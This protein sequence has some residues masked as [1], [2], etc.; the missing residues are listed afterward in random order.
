MGDSSPVR[1]RNSALSALDLPRAA[2]SLECW[3]AQW[4]G[5]ENHQSIFMCKVFPQS[6]PAA[7]NGQVSSKILELTFQFSCMYFS[8]RQLKVM[9]SFIT[10]SFPIT[11]IHISSLVRTQ[12]QVCA[13]MCVRCVQ[14]P[15]QKMSWC[16]NIRVRDCIQA[17]LP[18]VVLSVQDKWTNERNAR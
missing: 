5:S 12:A 17:L 11:T 15:L 1:D 16:K 14:G 10:F 8:Y 6:A 18:Q 13:R 3:R 4:W 7:M 9:F 2:A